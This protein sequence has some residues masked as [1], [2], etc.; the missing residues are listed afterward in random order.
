[1]LRFRVFKNG[2]A[3]AN[4]DLSTAYLVGSDSVPIRGE[5]AYDNGEIVCKKRAAGPAALSLMWESKNFGSVLLETTRLPERDEPYILNL[6]L[7]RGRMMRLMQ[8]RE[9]WGIFDLPDL[10]AM[11]EKSMEARD[12]LL[13]A[14]TSQDNPAKAS[15]YAD[16]CLEMVLPISE[17][18]ALAHADLLLQRRIATRNFPRGAFGMR[19]EHSI[20]LEAYR[21]ALVPNADF[22]RMPMWWKTIEP[23]EQQF[24]WHPIDEWMAFLARARVPVVAG[25]LV[26]F[27]EVSIPEWLYIWEHDYETVRDLLYEHIERVITRYGA[28]VALWNVLSGL[29]VNAQFSFTFD[30][31]MDVTRMAVNLVKKVN[32]AGRTM[33]EITQPW[34]EYYANNQRS[35]P[36]MLYADM[37]VQSGIPF[38]VFGVQLKFGMPRDGAWQRDLFQVSTLLDRFASLGKPVMI[39]ALQVPSAPPESVP[40]IGGSPGVWR[41]PW[42]DALQA[43]WLEAVTDIALS[44]PFVEAI[45]WQDLVDIPAK[46]LSLGQ[47]MPFGGLTNPDLS[48]KPALRTWASLRRAVMNF[49][50]PPPGAP[51]AP[52][53]TG[54][55]GTPPGPAG[56]QNLP[57]QQMGPGPENPP[58]PNRPPAPSTP[59]AT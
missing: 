7:A 44:K 35:I 42:T 49:R 46:G 19:V 47:S 3:P 40:G 21:R 51:G 41:R 4:L 24:N 38:D 34:G 27:T 16:R 33:I 1:M 48:P 6:E 23:Q 39:S 13:D 26:H 37:I 17:Q 43:K 5:F 30:Q 11:N 29:H 58:D 31:L 56:P 32:Q 20:T 22:V 12:L 15:E 52:G 18:A 2:N 9:E 57:P 10:A 53:T 28:N 25:P 50:Q 14:I 45:C 36:P 55:P 59:P 54:S 8:K